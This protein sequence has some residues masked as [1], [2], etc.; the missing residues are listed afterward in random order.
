MISDLYKAKQQIT[1]YKMGEAMLKGKVSEVQD[2]VV[3]YK[4]IE[5]NRR[6]AETETLGIGP[7]VDYDAEIQKALE[8]TVSK[9]N[10]PNT[11]L[12]NLVKI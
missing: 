8:K 1:W 7:E 12:N 5:D 4:R 9:Q 3:E 11:Y 6:E 10:R 2:L